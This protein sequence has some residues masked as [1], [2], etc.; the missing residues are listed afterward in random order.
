MKYNFDEIVDRNGT[1]CLKYDALER[2][3]GVSDLLPVWVADSD[4]RVPEFV[5]DAIAQRLQHPVLG[6]TYRGD[7]FYD[8]IVR[9]VA[10]RGGWSIQKDWILYSAG[11]VAGI[12]FAMNALTRQG[13]GVLIQT[14]VYPPFAMMVEEN[15][16]C[17][18]TN[19]LVDNDGHYEINFEDFENKLK[20]V[21]LFI[22]CNP[23]NP[24]G[25]VFTR[26]ELKRMGDLCVEY[27]VYIISD[28]IHSDIIMKPHKHVHIAS[29][30]PEIDRCTVTLMAPSKTF[31]IAGLSTSITI[32]S[33]PKLRKAYLSELGKF[34]LG[35]GNIFGIEAL[36]AAYRHGGEWV[37]E[38][39]DYL[40]VNMDYVEAFCRENMPNV[41]VIR[42]EAT[43][44]MW[45]DFNA[46]GV[47]EDALQDALIH[48]GKVALNRGSDYGIT[49]SGFM[50]L[51]VSAPLAVIKEAM[52]RIKV[53]Y[54]SIG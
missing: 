1:N 43:Y 9:W 51:N 3:F 12:G 15:N 25:R 53:T 39:N 5:T 33:N 13:A 4:F 19:T 30:S 26:D 27:G 49:G 23:H 45:L 46:L 41:R 50:R 14:P 18:V 20:E 22:L 34:H 8:S 48:Q 11:V 40:S 16:R 44:L 54:D 47:S 24:V 32:I 38:M 31:N 28:E 21:D 42:P 29:L 52:R 7:E 6:Y 35:G 36:A 2:F 10:V 17:L 37:D